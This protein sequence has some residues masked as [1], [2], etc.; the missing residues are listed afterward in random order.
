MN[1]IEYVPLAMRTLSPLPAE[2]QKHHASLGALTEVGELLDNFKKHLAYGRQ[3]DLPNLL[4]E[5]GDLNWY[6]AL[7]AHIGEFDLEYIT[8]DVWDDYPVT[9]LLYTLSSEVAAFAVNGEFQHSRR[10]SSILTL[11]ASLLRRYDF[12]VEESLPVNIAKLAARYGDKYSDYCATNR[13]LFTEREI[14][15]AGAK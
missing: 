9:S 2:M 8:T 6:L 7:A 1:L 10:C 13:D 4:E 3:L 14:L 5:C 12:T 15:E 11:E